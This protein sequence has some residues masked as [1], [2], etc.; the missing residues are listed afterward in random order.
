MKNIETKKLCEKVVEIGAIYEYNSNSYD[1]T[2]CPF[3]LEWEYGCAGSMNTIEHSDDCGWL[4]AIKI[5]NK[6]E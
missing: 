2:K 5:L 3:C 4:L 6:N 1:A